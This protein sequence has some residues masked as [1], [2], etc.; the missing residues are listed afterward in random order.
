MERYLGDVLRLMPKTVAVGVRSGV[1]LM[2][3]DVVKSRLTDDNPPYLNRD[4]GT[5]IRSVTASPRFHLDDTRATGEFGSNLDYARKHEEG[6]S[7]TEQVP[8]HL[9]RRPT[10]SRYARAARRA[11]FS[12]RDMRTQRALMIPV[13]AHTRHVH[14]R[15]RHMFRDTVS[16]NT[17]EANLRVRRALVYLHR[18]RKVPAL[19]ALGRAA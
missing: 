12:A 17:A 6:F 4:T 7:G 9:R 3:R 16:A 10:K 11:G 8:A 14:Y 5:L 2:V 1:F 19:S 13:R 15:A 18:E